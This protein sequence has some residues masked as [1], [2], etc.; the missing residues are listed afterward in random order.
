MMEGLVSVTAHFQASSA[1]TWQINVESVCV[2]REE[3][4]EQLLAPY[5]VSGHGRVSNSFATFS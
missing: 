4:W 3:I 1:I 5:L 2:K